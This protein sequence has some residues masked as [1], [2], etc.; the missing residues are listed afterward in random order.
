[1]SWF[2]KKQTNEIYGPVA[3]NVLKHWAA[4]GRI[5]PEDELSEDQKTW[6]SPSSVDDLAMDWMLELDEGQI[7]GPLHAMCVVLLL[8]EGQL[9]P[10]TNTKHKDSE[11]CLPAWE[12]GLKTATHGMA[13]LRLSMDEMHQRLSD[14]EQKLLEK[15]AP[16]KPVDP[17]GDLDP[18]RSAKDAAKWKNLYE[19]VS[20]NTSKEI[21]TLKETARTKGQQLKDTQREADLAKTHLS[22]AEQRVKAMQGEGGSDSERIN[23]LMQAS[24]ELSRNYDELLKQVDSKNDEIQSLSESRRRA[25]EQAKTSVDEMSERLQREQGEADTARS[26]FFELEQSHL[27]LVKVYR[28]LNG[29][30]IRLRQEGPVPAVPSTS[31]YSKPEGSVD[32]PQAPE[33]RKSKI[34]LN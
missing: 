24:D 32:E 34:R 1:M 16:E 9:S 6:R 31:M 28:E 22:Q 27:Q 20:T 11:D 3:L 30:Y 26:R 10:E 29:R 12:L 15:P 13:Q 4:D 17:S 5:A 21:Q 25:E 7:Y 19:E 8:E 18:T 14:A 33:K 23:A 2:V